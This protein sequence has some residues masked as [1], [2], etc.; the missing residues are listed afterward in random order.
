MKD[1][2]AAELAKIHI[3]KK[4]LGLIDDD[5]RAIVTRVSARCRRGTPVDSSAAMDQ[6]ERR[7][8][9][10]EFKRL[11]WREK[12]ARKGPELRELSDSAAPM[13]KKIRALWLALRD[14]GELRDPSEKNLLI[15]AE[16]ITGKKAFAWMTVPELSA[17]IEALKG[18]ADRVANQRGVEREPGQEG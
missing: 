14:L 7:A 1:T 15:F 10:E 5:Y 3:A 9:I 11:G 4:D 2:R 8:L 13:V 18:W 12:A 16:R 17:V 6:R